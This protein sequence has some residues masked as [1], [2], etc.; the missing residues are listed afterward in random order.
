MIHDAGY[1]LAGFCV[2]FAFAIR[3]VWWLYKFIAKG[4]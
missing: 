1:L 2:G 4:P 3:V